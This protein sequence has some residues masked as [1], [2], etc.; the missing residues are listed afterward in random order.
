MSDF[1]NRHITDAEATL[2]SSVSNT[3][4]AF[5]LPHNNTLLKDITFT[6]IILLLV[7]FWG[8]PAIIF[9][10]K[11]ES[12]LEASRAKAKKN[13]DSD[14]EYL[15]KLFLEKTRRETGNFRLTLQGAKELKFDSKKTRNLTQEILP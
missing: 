4:T 12:R 9:L 7:P 14:E 8:I 6:L 10:I 5:S 13:E 15:D 3:V 1:N 2:V 11:D